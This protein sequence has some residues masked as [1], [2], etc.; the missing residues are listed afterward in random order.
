A[1]G[2]SCS[3]GGLRPIL[4]AG[5]QDVVVGL[6][7]RRQVQLLRL[8]KVERRHTVRFS[9]EL[10]RMCGARQPRLFGLDDHCIDRRKLQY[11]AATGA[12]VT[13]GGGVITGDGVGTGVGGAAA[14]TVTVQG[15]KEPPE[16]ITPIW[17]TPGTASDGI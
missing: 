3:R 9:Q 8:R 14:L 11:G 17:Y 10:A 12:G 4:E 15:L 2:R 16:S 6:A 13:T 7:S 5:R 1:F